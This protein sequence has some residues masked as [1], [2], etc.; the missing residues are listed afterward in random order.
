MNGTGSM[1]S[2]AHT[3]MLMYTSQFLGGFLNTLIMHSGILTLKCYLL[4]SN[5]ASVY[6][7][8]IHVH[9]Y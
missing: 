4:I 6:K 5:I 7:H 8:N 9:S 2:I 3:K 1:D